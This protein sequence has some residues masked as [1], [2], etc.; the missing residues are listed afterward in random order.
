MEKIVYAVNNS[1]EIVRIGQLVEEGYR[2][3][4]INQWGKFSPTSIGA[5]AAIQNCVQT[6]GSF[7]WTY[8]CSGCG[9]HLAATA[10]TGH[11]LWPDLIPKGREKVLTQAQVEE[12]ST[13]FPPER[14]PK[15]LKPFFNGIC[16]LGKELP[17]EK[18]SRKPSKNP[19]H[20]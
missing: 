13:K 9:R 2:L 18:N 20:K 4:E 19:R 16:Y 1:L 3:K 17:C 10:D 5:T 6:Y 11:K 12:F 15:A 8:R 14:I 7:R